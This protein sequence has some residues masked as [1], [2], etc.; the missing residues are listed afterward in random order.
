[1]KFNGPTYF[2]YVVFEKG[3]KVIFESPDLSM[4]SFLDTDISRIAFSE[5]VKWGKSDEPSKIFDERRLEKTLKFIEAMN[6]FGLFSKSVKDMLAGM[7]KNP[8]KDLPYKIF[9]DKSQKIPRF[10]K[11]EIL[12][13][14]IVFNDKDNKYRLIP[15]GKNAYD[16]NDVSAIY[17]NLRENCEYRL[18]YEDAGK[19][20]IREMELKRNYTENK[21]SGEILKTNKLVRNLSF[22]GLYYNL[23]RYGESFKQPTLT[24]VIPFLIL[25]TSYW[26]LTD[27]WVYSSPPMD[28][29]SKTF[30]NAISTIFHIEQNKSG[31]IDSILK[32]FYLGIL[33]MYLIPLRRRFERKFRH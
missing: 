27:L 16:L 1:M 7:G 6:R 2:R 5:N 3:E 28:A 20:F 19:F 8:Y 22:T 32:V 14:S 24:V 26:F 33:G 31:L 4:V 25:S 10:A 18:R 30:T 12:F 23:F 21:N 15:S 17:R 29:L 13:E 9:G 11:G